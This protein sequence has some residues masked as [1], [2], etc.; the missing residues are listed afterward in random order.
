MRKITIIFS[1]G[2]ITFL[3]SC[4][5]DDSCYSCSKDSYWNGISYTESGPYSYDCKDD[6]ESDENYEARIKEKIENGYT[7]K[8]K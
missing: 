3:V 2:I 1:L 8:K 6:G 5:E 7:C 4:G